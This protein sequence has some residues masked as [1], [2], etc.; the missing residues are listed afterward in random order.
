MAIKK[1]KEYLVNYL[2]DIRNSNQYRDK[3]ISIMASR[4]GKLE[5]ILDVFHDK[6]GEEYKTIEE[7]RHDEFLYNRDKNYAR[8]KFEKIKKEREVEKIKKEKTKEYLLVDGYN[9]IFATE[10]LFI[11]KK[12]DFYIKNPVECKITSNGQVYIIN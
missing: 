3:K 1:K 11:Q 4:Y 7:Y 9:V 12:A 5:R 8:Y 10:E 2:N 6:L